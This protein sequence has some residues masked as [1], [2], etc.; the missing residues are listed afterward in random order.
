MRLALIEIP[1]RRTL[2]SGK[3]MAYR[4]RPKIKSQTQTSSYGW[5]IFICHF[6]F[7]SLKV[8]SLCL[9]VSKFYQFSNKCWS[10][11]CLLLIKTW[12]SFV[13]YVVLC[14]RLSAGVGMR[15]WNFQGFLLYILI[16]L[17]C[18]ISMEW[19]VCNFQEILIS[20]SFLIYRKSRHVR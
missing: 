4:A 2:I 16:S 3:E 13:G 10:H 14:F 11:L 9:L 15:G 20:L 8:H 6:R 17:I 19:G 12:V 5:S 1:H 7:L 18:V